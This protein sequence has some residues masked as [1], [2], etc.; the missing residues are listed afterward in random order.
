M[1]HGQQRSHER[2][3]RMQGQ[4]DRSR[5]CWIYTLFQVSASVIFAKYMYFDNQ[6]MLKKMI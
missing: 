3:R 4:A 1:Y 6:Q 2:K 5:H